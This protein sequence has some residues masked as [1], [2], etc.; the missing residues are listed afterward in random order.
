MVEIKK[1][2]CD[3]GRNVRVIQR[4]ELGHRAVRG[5]EEGHGRR[6]GREALSLR[7]FFFSRSLILEVTFPEAG[8]QLLR[9]GFPSSIP[10]RKQGNKEFPVICPHVLKILT[11]CD[12]LMFKSPTTC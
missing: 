12:V 4:R 2:G 3:G 7:P 6:E 11:T 5:G 1:M 9:E 10:L 8:F